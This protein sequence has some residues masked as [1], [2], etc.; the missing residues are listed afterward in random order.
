MR[1][2]GPL[3]WMTPVPDYSP[4]GVDERLDEQKLAQLRRWAEVLLADDRPDMRAAA[5]GLLMLAD[6]IERLWLTGRDAFADEIGTALA[7]RL[8]TEPTR[9]PTDRTD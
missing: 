4:A 7:H 9:A 3:P 6:E 5:R 8:S 2:L 1:Q